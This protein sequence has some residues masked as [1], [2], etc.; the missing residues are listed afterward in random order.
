MQLDLSSELCF[1]KDKFDDILDATLL[2]KHKAHRT[3]REM[4]SLVKSGPCA[5]IQSEIPGCGFGK[6]EFATQFLLSQPLSQHRVR[7]GKP[8]AHE[9]QFWVVRIEVVSMSVG[10]LGSRAR[11]LRKER[12]RRKKRRDKGFVSGCA[13][14]RGCKTHVTPTI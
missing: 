3:E 12:V 2:A 10:K 7:L 14:L 8:C 6:S 11:F 1:L 4:G 9:G 13:P 5:L